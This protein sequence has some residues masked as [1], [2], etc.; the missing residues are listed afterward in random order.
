M[1]VRCDYFD[2]LRQFCVAKLTAQGCGVEATDDAEAALLKYLNVLHHVSHPS[3]ET[4][5]GRVSFARRWTP[6]PSGFGVQSP[7]SSTHRRPATI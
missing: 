2:D 3:P 1:L 6:F 4:F 5:T 7:R